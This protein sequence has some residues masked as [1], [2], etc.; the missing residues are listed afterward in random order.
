MPFHFN[1]N[2]LTSRKHIKNNTI[3][4]PGCSYNNQTKDVLG[5]FNFSCVGIFRQIQIRYQGNIEIDSFSD[6]RDY[7]I[8]INYKNKFIV[9]SNKH[10]RQ[11]IDGSLFKY[12]GSIKKVT[13]AIV[14][15]SSPSPQNIKITQ[16]DY[17]ISDY[18][19]NE[20]NIE[21]SDFLFESTKREDDIAKYKTHLQDNNMAYNTGSLIS[22]YSPRNIP[23]EYTKL[24]KPAYK[25]RRYVVKDKSIKNKQNKSYFSNNRS[26]VPEDYRY[27]DIKEQFCGNC[28][29]LKWNKFCKLWK[30]PVKSNFVCNNWKE[31]TK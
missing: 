8:I 24:S 28:H 17:L 2:Q 22:D 4:S 20:A 5:E 25:D 29:F 12:Y 16:Y 7:S 21:D 14:F 11:N 30:A 27:A 9:I 18:Q 3:S 6:S 1:I 19:E 10:N 13:S 23:K 15:D 31:H 26:R